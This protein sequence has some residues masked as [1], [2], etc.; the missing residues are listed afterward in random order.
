MVLCPDDTT[1]YMDHCVN[2]QSHT[3]DAS[4]LLQ[5]PGFDP[6]PVNEQYGTGTDFYLGT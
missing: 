4:L 2:L 6:R 1:V 5:R 3:Q